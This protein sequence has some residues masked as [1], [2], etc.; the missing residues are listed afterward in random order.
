[1]PRGTNKT[2]KPNQTIGQ[3]IAAEEQRQR[4]GLEL[5]ASENYPSKA[6][7]SAVGSILSDKYA[8]GYP[9]KRYYAGTEVID[10]VEQLAIDHVK[11]LFGAEHANVQP[12]SGSP[13]NMAVYYGLLEFGDTILG[14]SLTAGGHLTHGHKVNFSGRAYKAESYGVDPKTGLIDYDEV[15]RI[16]KQVKPKLLVSGAT[17]YPRIIDWKRM[18]SI[19]QSVGALHMVD[20]SH[21]AG[22]VAAGVVPNPVPFADVVTSTTHKT[23]R[24]PRGAIILCRAK[25]AKQI[26]R[27]VF[28]GLQG[29]PHEN[30]IAGIAVALEEA[31]TAEFKKYAQAVVAN[32]KALGEALTARGF[33]LATGGTDTH[34]IL[35]DLSNKKITGAEAENALAAIGITVNKNTVPGERRS[36]FDPSGIRIGTPAITTRGATQ[37][38]MAMIAEW[39]NAGISSA[40][41]AKKLDAIHTQVKAFATKMPLPGADN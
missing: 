6:V 5:I 23:L 12:Y 1:M 20:M 33:S 17:A 37:K 14:M 11:K 25:F 21:V 32:A 18:Q 13:A 34:L 26:D 19:A 28:P 9:G 2:A 31:N 39:I 40:Q 30:A 22:L 27:A 41:D 3:L 15:E 7:L 38:D 8:E 29:G 16:A 35:V 4:S 36:A 24:G 10:Q